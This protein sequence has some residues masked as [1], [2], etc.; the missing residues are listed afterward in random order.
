MSVHN[1]DDFDLGEMAKCTSEIRRLGSNAKSLDEFASALVRYFYEDFVQDSAGNKACA[2]VRLFQTERFVDLPAELKTIAVSGLASN[3]CNPSMR[4]M[5]LRATAGDKH[6][7]NASEHSIHHRVIP[8]PSEELVQ[9]MPMIAQLVL[10]L[11]L[12][13]S[14]VLEPPE[15]ILICKS[16]QDYN[17]FY[18]DDA[19]DCPVIPAQKEFVEPHQVKSVLG[20]GGMLPS[21]NLFA[22]ILFSKIKLSRTVAER[23]RSL[24][25]AVNLAIMPFE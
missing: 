7:W 25:L 15:H 17:I 5:V 1:L 24:A 20:F 16:E 22:V 12:R 9:K 21:G 18:V 6:E 11:G 23:F 13:I 10:D 4:C 14:D 2:L 3:Y 8:L 19:H